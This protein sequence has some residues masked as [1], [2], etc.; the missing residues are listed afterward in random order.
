MNHTPWCA[1]AKNSPVSNFADLLDILLP[2][3]GG[4][5]AVLHAYF[6]ASSRT[7][8]TFVVAGYAFAKPQVKKFDKEWWSLFGKYG[9]C[10]MKDL[11]HRTGRFKELGITDKDKLLKLAVKI[12]VKRISFGVAVSCDVNEL[13]SLLPTWIRG[14]DHAYPVC[15]HL[16]MLFLGTHVTKLWPG[17]EIA[18]FFETGDP[19]S[20]AAHKFMQHISQMPV[21]KK[22]CLYHSH[23]FI[24][25]KDALSL[26]AADI[27][28]WEWGKYFDETITMRSRNMRMSL[29]K[30]ISKNNSYD[31]S[32]YKVTYITGAPLR[33]WAKQVAAL[34][35][36]QLAEDR[37]A[38]EKRASA[39]LPSKA[40]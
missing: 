7:S 35:L 26:Q 18:Y 24:E 40:D 27:L 5:L 14:F 29:A 21:L 25:K 3:K 36:I 31:S 4:R 30:L 39:F 1:H 13:N 12:I 28:A 32:R 6:D 10:H 15:C 34:G 9:G 38:K 16:A 8:G 33:T 17:E 2:H 19:H 20:A 23:S 22:Q 11:A 37:E